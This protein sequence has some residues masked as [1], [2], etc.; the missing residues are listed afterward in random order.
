MSDEFFVSEM[1]KDYGPVVAVDGID[2]SIEPGIVHCIAGPNGSG[3][4]TLLGVMLGLIRP[5]DGTVV[6]PASDRIG[7]GFQEPAFYDS[8]T[9]KENLDVFRT[10]AGDPDFEWVKEIVEVFNLSQVFHRQAS[11]LSGGYSKQLDL[12]LAL[13][14]SP[15]FLLLDEPLADLDDVTRESLLDFLEEYA[16][17][18]NAVVV[19]SHRIDAFAPTLDRLTVMHEGE[20]VLDGRRE[21]IDGTERIKRVYRNAIAENGESAD[22]GERGGDR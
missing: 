2:L 6:R 16:A 1:V 5:T 7:A 4:S 17:E 12:T 8:L 15:D 9:V 11:E 22:R 18:G 20:I 3:K 10:L 13:L 14:K 19:S 21:E